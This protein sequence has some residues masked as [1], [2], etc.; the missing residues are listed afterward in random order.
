MSPGVGTQAANCAAP[1]RTSPTSQR[2]HVTVCDDFPTTDYSESSKDPIAIVI[3]SN[4]A[5]HPF[6]RGLDTG[7]CCNMMITSVS[8]DEGAPTLAGDGGCPLAQVPGNSPHVY[9]PP[10]SHETGIPYQMTK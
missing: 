10:T 6:L 5:D 9:P 2:I 7:Y 1:E 4:R 3:N 8:K